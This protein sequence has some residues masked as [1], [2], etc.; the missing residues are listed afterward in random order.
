MTNRELNTLMHRELN[1]LMHRRLNT[2]ARHVRHA[3]EL[4]ATKTH[5]R[6]RH[7]LLPTANTDTRP[8][9]AEE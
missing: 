1:T 9:G 7:V 4:G 2:D 8:Q 6:T 5:A 3:R